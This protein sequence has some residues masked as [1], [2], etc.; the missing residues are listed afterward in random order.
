MSMLLCIVVKV[1]AINCHG[2][3]YVLV[4]STYSESLGACCCKNLSHTRSAVV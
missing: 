1:Q 4:G 2:Q 3:Q